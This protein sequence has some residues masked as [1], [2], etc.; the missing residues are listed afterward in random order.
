[1]DLALQQLT[2]FAVFVAMIFPAYDM[3]A[4][5]A[6]DECAECPHCKALAIERERRDRELQSAYAREHGLDVDEDDQRRIG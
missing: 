2:L 6:P 1:M 3:R 5:L 4:S